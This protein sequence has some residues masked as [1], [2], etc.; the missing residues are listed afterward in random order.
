MIYWGRKHPW[1]TSL[2]WWRLCRFRRRRRK[3]WGRRMR[4]IRTRARCMMKGVWVQNGSITT[5]QTLIVQ[6]SKPLPRSSTT[7]IRHPPAKKLKPVLA[8]G[9]SGL[10]T[11]KHKRPQQAERLKRRPTIHGLTPWGTWMNHH[12]DPWRGRRRDTISQIV[13]RCA[14]WEREGTNEHVDRCWLARV[15]HLELCDQLKLYSV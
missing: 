8:K 1:R 10:K 11:F 9:D 12:D 13:V 4:L 6:S 15:W 3:S 14:C 7:L 2:W 5:K